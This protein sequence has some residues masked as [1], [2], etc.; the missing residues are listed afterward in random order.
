M[1]Y[2]TAQNKTRT[3][4]KLACSCVEIIKRT[5]ARLNTHMRR[6]VGV[7]I[8]L[9]CRCQFLFVLSN[10]LVL[11]VFLNDKKVPFPRLRP[12]H[13]ELRVEPMNDQLDGGDV[14]T[15][16]HNVAKTTNLKQVLSSRMTRAPNNTELLVPRCEFGCVCS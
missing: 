5:Q 15:T 11:F 12:L 8:Q 16:G 13:V 6:P 4:P 3:R 7:I 14:T 10:L 1:Q 9:R 2:S